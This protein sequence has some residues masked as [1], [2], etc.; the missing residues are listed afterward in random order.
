MHGYAPTTRDFFARDVF[1]VAPTLLGCVLSRMDAAGTVSLRITEV[2]AYAGETDPG[3]HTYRGRTARNATMFGPPGH[4]Y[5][6]FNYG[7][8]HA[9]NL[10]TS[11]EGSPRGCLVRAGE[12]VAGEE[13]ARERRSHTPRK[14]PVKH[15]DLARGPG[16]VAQALGATLADDG[17][18]LWG[19]Q[20]SFLVPLEPAAFT[21]A[22][23]PRVG[24]SGEAGAF[25]WRY[26][27][28]G[29]PT[30]SA[31]RP[32]RGVIPS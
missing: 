24:V 29:D 28:A 26:W 30:V 12:V 13:L 6:Y 7:L 32:G 25:P 19:G 16:R 27:I 2:E 18:D 17:A 14:Q 9:V 15:R 31:Y 10:V 22:T 5:A 1:A 3:A 11:A 23:G 21:V 8:H 20:W 4:V